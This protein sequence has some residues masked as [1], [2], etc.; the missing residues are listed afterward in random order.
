MIE[1]TPV[2]HFGV[3]LKQENFNAVMEKLKKHG[4]E[5]KEL[6]SD[7]GAVWVQDFTGNN[8]LI[9]VEK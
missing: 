8:L 3:F 7:K 6:P 5:V 4:V 2:P 1:G 9:Q